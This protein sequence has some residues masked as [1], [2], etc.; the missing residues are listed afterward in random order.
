MKI[1]IKN[2]LSVLIR[3]R[4]LRGASDFGRRM[5]AAGFPMSASHASRFLKAKMPAT[6]IRFLR[7]A[8][9]VL[10]CTPDDLYDMTIELDRDEPLDPTWILPRH[11]VVL[12]K[13]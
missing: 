9:H 4:G 8:C 2:R 12:R 11:A 5:T 13:N 10:Q 7:A 3:V 6:T 1:E